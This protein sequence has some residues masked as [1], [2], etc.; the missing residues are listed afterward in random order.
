MFFTSHMR[1]A[2]NTVVVPIGDKVGRIRNGERTSTR[3]MDMHFHTHKR[4]KDSRTRTRKKDSRTRNK[5]SCS[6][7]MKPR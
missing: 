2:D 4:K 7:R 3:S 1:S 5:D 6:R